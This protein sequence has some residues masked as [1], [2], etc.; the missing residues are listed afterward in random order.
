M[1]VKRRRGSMKEFEGSRRGMT[2]TGAMVSPIQQHV[3]PF[4]KGLE[5]GGDEHE[6]IMPPSPASRG[7]FSTKLRYIK[8][9]AV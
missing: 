2:T 6:R 8:F 1:H 3:A 7:L 4:V 5:W 9:G